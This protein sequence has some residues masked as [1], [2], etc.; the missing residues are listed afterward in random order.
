MIYCINQELDKYNVTVNGMEVGL[1]NTYKDRPALLAA[2]F[3]MTHVPFEY[4]H[5]STIPAP[6][7]G[8]KVDAVVEGLLSDTL[9]SCLGNKMIL[10]LLE[11]LT[12][13]EFYEYILGFDLSSLPIRK[14]YDSDE[15]FLLIVKARVFAWMLREWIRGGQRVVPDEYLDLELAYRQVIN[16]VNGGN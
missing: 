13:L 14:F 15:N 3:I 4:E 1:Y 6:L 12:P 7:R 11:F 10:T 16:A 5:T 2:V 9:I 8:A